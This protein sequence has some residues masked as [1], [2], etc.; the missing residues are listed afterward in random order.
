[1]I[2]APRN[3]I[4]LSVISSL[5]G[6]PTIETES[7]DFVRMSCLGT[8]IPE[9]GWPVVLTEVRRILKTG[10]AVEV[11][12]DEM[13]W[14][15]SKYS[16]KEHGV[17]ALKGLS[18]LISTKSRDNE[19]NLHPIDRYFKQMLVEKYGM[20]ATPHRTID[21][22]ME[23]IFGA[24]DK[25]HFRVELPSPIF[26]IFEIEETR[27]SGNLFQAF[28]SK[29]DA[30]PPDTATKAQRVLGSTPAGERISDPFLIF[31]PHGLC[32]LDASEVRMAA[33]GSMHTVLSCRASLIDSI[34]G[35][36]AEGEDLDAVTNMLW[37]YEE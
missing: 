12:D 25:K 23:T 22:S 1:M 10:G 28:R 6:L 37:A 17:V 34:V 11:I 3:L 24:N 5:N 33:C 35:S 15:Y 18:S 7:V 36:S 16:A 8:S 19:D 9:T 13:V 2:A 26:K 30:V 29:K 14:G 32:R 31:Y 27:R 20:P 4:H 21:R